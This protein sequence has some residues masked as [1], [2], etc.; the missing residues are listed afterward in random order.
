VFF[1]SF[2]V[3]NSDKIKSVQSQFCGTH[4]IDINSWFK[5]NNI[6]PS[7][8][9]EIRQFIFEEWLQKKIL[10][11]K[12]K[13]SSETFLV[14]ICDTPTDSFISLL[15]QKISSAFECG[16]CEVILITE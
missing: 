16:F 5:Q 11:S 15:K 12:A 10:S 2:I 9:N 14:I 6:S 7:E 4:Q 3:T 1:K 8:M 13:V